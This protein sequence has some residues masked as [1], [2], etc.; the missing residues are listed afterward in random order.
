MIFL[1]P[2]IV[3]NRAMALA[4]GPD[5]I[6]QII[7]WVDKFYTSGIINV[8]ERDRM[9]GICEENRPYLDSGLTLD[10]IVKEA[11]N[12]WWMEHYNIHMSVAK[13]R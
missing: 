10:P 4:R 5:C 13:S 6:N 9:I 11:R 8:L 3:F 1:E 12:S 7:E 2:E